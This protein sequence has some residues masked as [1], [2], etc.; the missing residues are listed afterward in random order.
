MAVSEIEVKPESMAHFPDGKYRWLELH[1]RGTIYG[2][3]AIAAR[4]DDLELHLT[5]TRWGPSTRRNLQQDV[6]WLQAEARRLGL[7]RILGVRASCDGK[8]DQNFFR[9]TASFGFRDEIVLQM[10][11]L[12]VS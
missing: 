12:S 1:D 3:A 9:F 5:M 7:K 2:H 10:A 4:G 8:F 6:V 11:S